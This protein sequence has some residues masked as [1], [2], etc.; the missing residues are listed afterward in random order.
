MSLSLLMTTALLSSTPNGAYSCVP[1]AT[2]LALALND[3]AVSYRDI[4]QEMTFDEIGRA[5]IAD[6]VGSC[7]KRGLFAHA[8]H[9]ASN[10][11]LRSWLNS[12]A[13]VVAVPKLGDQ[14]HAMC[15]YGSNEL[16]ADT[17]TP[18][19]NANPKKLERL[20]SEDM[21]CLV[22][23]KRQ[24]V[25]FYTMMNVFLVVFPVVCLVQ[26]FQEF[27]LA[28]RLWIKGSQPSAHAMNA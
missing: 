9:S 16:V 20:L 10:S 8:Y 23:S 2:C 3:V 22:V 25:G 24:P 13:V 7:R 27:L 18:V 21:C 12:G 17:R 28:G 4:L 19:H 1:T 6:L 26:V 11:Q 5:S 15:L 14:T